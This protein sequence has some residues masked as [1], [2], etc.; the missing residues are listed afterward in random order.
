MRHP[1]MRRCI[2]LGCGLAILLL[3]ITGAVSFAVPVRAAGDTLSLAITNGSN[4]TYGVAPTFTAVVTFGTKP[5]TSPSWQVKVTIEGGGSF[6]NTSAPTQSSDGMTLTFTG[7]HPTNSVSAGAHSATAQFTNP[8]TGLTVTS[9]TVSFTVNK[10]TVA[11]ACTIAM[12]GQN[13]IGVGKPISVQMTP[14]SGN[15]S[16]PAEWLS[17]TFTVKLDGPTHA[18]YSNLTA[19][20]SFVVAA[21][22]PTQ[23]GSYTL[24]CIFNGSANYASSSFTASQS[25]I[26]SSLHA[27]GTVQLYS[28]PTTLTAG[29]KID[30]Y[31]VFQPASGLSTPTGQFTLSFGNHRTNA[32]TL[33]STGT[34]LIYFSTITSLAGVT[35]IQVAYMGDANYAPATTHFTLT[36]PA[37]PPGIDDGAGANAQATTTT[38]AT[39][40]Q[41][42]GDEA[43]TPTVADSAGA[44][45][46]SISDTGIGSNLGLILIAALVIMLL[47]GVLGGTAIIVIYR[48]RRAR[49][50]EDEQ[51][52]YGQNGRIGMGAFDANDPYRRSGQYRNGGQ[53][54]QYGRSGQYP[55]YGQSAQMRQVGQVGRI[56]QMGE[57]GPTARYQ[58]PAQYGQN[59]QNGMTGK[60]RQPGQYGQSG[61]TERYGQTGRHRQPGQYGQG[62]TAKHRQYQQRDVSPDDGPYP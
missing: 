60:H 35:D 23:N 16:L 14:S 17:G 12:N 51:A 15:G 34:F 59:G 2:R 54:G 55:Q 49:A 26:I 45:P 56:G 53:N 37:I 8:E 50:D 11:L 27:L 25:Y 10:A 41:T 20:N 39:T 22:A 3:A 42:P 6:V 57:T 19:N 38:T 1:W 48:I 29:Q 36:N 44:A 52:P 13:V 9:N 21:T 43:A 46:P 30:F 40:T 4:L 5:T 61:L 28:N 58:R 32:F 31:V 18:T 7:L 33:S 62:Q 47:L 24:T